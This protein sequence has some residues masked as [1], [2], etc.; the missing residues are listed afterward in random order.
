VRRRHAEHGFVTIQYVAATAL[1]LV[2][3]VLVANLLV[4]LYARGAIRDALDEGV[5][6]AAP[7]DATSAACEARAHEVLDA[8]VRGPVA[9][10]DVHCAQDGAWVRADARVALE[11]WL[12]M[13][14]PAWRM[15]L[16]AEALRED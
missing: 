12:P 4:D 11:S 16:H 5:R 6:A 8:L 3:L 15:E 1:S 10:V 14:V 13:L 9:R 2:L 7:V